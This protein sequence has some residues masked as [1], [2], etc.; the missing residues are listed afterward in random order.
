[1]VLG[2][3]T[4][5]FLNF[6]VFVSAWKKAKIAFPIR[7]PA[8]AATQTLGHCEKRRRDFAFPGMWKDTT[9]LHLRCGPSNKMFELSLP[10]WLSPVNRGEKSSS[11]QFVSSYFFTGGMDTKIQGL[12]PRIDG[13]LS[14]LKQAVISDFQKNTDSWAL[15]FEN[16]F[17]Q[18]CL[19]S[20]SS[21]ATY[22][23]ALKL[24]QG[25]SDKPSDWVIFPGRED[26]VIE[27]CLAKLRPV[28][29]FLG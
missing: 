23:H 18:N 15:L 29:Q 26:A 6:S 10:Y 14:S 16:I 11:L 24:W 17:K 25:F 7:T 27:L 28:L 22:F 20:S 12:P 8:E 5:S 1:M 4:W 21:P 13:P 19:K 2:G 3:P 9:V